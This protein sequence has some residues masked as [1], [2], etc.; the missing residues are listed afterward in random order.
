MREQFDRVVCDGAD[1]CIIGKARPHAGTDAGEGALI[2]DGGGRGHGARPSKPRGLRK[3]RRAL[4]CG[5][6]VPG[7][8]IQG[9]MGAMG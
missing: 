3:Y 9:I 7:T 8:Q 6:G 4:L 1:C 5:A 2:G